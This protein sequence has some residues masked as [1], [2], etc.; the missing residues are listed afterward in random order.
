M[1][2]LI[3]FLTNCDQFSVNVKVVDT[4]TSPDV[5]AKSVNGF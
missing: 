3:I 5:E 2:V 1:I 4:M